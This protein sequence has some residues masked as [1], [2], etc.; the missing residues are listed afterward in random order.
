MQIELVTIPAGPFLMGSADGL[1][2]EQPIHE[3]WVSAFALAVHPVTNAEYRRFVEATQ[4]RPAAMCAEPRFA[5][6]QQ[7]VVGVNWFDAVA[8]CAWLRDGTGKAFRL[9]T[10]AEREKAARG[11]APATHYPWGDDP[12]GS[13]HVP[14][15]EQLPVVGLDRANGYGL[16]NT[17][18]LVHEWC[19]DWYAADYYRHSP[20]RDPC[21]PSEGTRRASRGGSWRH[22]VPV[23]RCA[24]RSSLAPDRLYSDYGFRVAVAP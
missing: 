7:P 16:H 6:P 18:D 17:G 20:S 11:G 19:S 14:T 10:E 13:G 1:P 4:H 2:D 21:G 12:A 24:A 8:Y 23:S 3:V 15:P 9:P 5:L 22:H